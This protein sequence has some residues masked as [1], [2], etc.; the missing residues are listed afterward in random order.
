[1][2]VLWAIG[3]SSSSNSTEG[4]LS[5]KMEVPARMSSILSFCT[6]CLDPPLRLVSLVGLC[7]GAVKGWSAVAVEGRVEV[8]GVDSLSDV[9]IIKGD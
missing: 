3:R 7:T 9:V 4:Q 1:M 8:V 2:L 5:E 6:V